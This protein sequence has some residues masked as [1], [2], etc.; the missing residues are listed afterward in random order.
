MPVLEWKT[1]V[2]CACTHHV[3]IRGARHARIRCVTDSQQTNQILLCTSKPHICVDQLESS[4]VVEI[5]HH[6][7][8]RWQR[9]CSDFSTR[10]R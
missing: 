2:C 8:Q 4:A 1:K 6:E 10:P 5:V 9:R 3:G 7:M